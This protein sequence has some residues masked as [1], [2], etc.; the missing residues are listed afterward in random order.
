M[1]IFCD[2]FLIFIP[3]MQLSY[4]KSTTRLFSLSNM[5]SLEQKEMKLTF[6]TRRETINRFQKII[7][8]HGESF[9]QIIFSC[10]YPFILLG[11]ERPCEIYVFPVPKP[12]NNMA[13][14]NG[15]KI[16]FPR[17]LQGLRASYNGLRKLQPKLL[18]IQ[19]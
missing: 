19:Q 1:I 7:I 17:V 18:T 3:Y 13:C 10:R 12:E 2:I 14:R 6:T 16:F 9:S 4:F 5:M 8:G 11:R 15:S